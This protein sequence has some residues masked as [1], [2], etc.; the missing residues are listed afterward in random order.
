MSEATPPPK[1][2]VLDFQKRGSEKVAQKLWGNKVAVRMAVTE[3]GTTELW[4]YN[5]DGT[6]YEYAVVVSPIESSMS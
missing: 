4:W 1:G 5:A 3:D 6:L 2:Y